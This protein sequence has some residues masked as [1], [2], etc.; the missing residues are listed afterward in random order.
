MKRI[1]AASLVVFALAACAKTPSAPGGGG[2]SGVRGTAV[3]GPACPGPVRLDS[4]CADQ[5]I[6]IAIRVENA[7]GKAVTTVH[8]AA[9]G[10]FEVILPPGNYRLVPQLQQNGGFPHGGPL[11]VTVKAGEFSQVTL[12]LDSGL[13]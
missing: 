9:D 1:A 13:R 11:D 10:T 2:A 8:S 7:S 5:P 12:K 4:P 6:A 3:V